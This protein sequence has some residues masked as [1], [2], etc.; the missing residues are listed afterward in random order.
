MN[1][2]RCQTPLPVDAVYCPRCGAMSSPTPAPSRGAGGPGDH[3]S[4]RGA[5][6]PG[7]HGSTLSGQ[8][9]IIHSLGV[10]GTTKLESGAVFANRYEV[11]NKLGEGGMGIVYSAKDQTSGL[12]L[13]LK[14]IHPD[15]VQ[16][17][18]AVKRLMSEGL[19]AREIRHPNIVAVYD[20]S[21]WGGQPYFTMEYVRGRNLRSWLVEN[22]N[23][24][25]EVALDVAVG[26]IKAILAG[27]AEAHRMGIVHRDLKPENILLKGEPGA[28]G[29]QLKIVDFGI[30]KAVG[31][32]RTSKTSFGAGGG[33]GTPLYMAPEQMTSSEGIKPSAD[34]YSLSVMLYEMLMD[35]LPQARFEPVSKHRSGVPAAIDALIEKGLSV[36]PRSRFQTAAEFAEA[37]DRALPGERAPVAPPPPQVAEPPATVIPPNPRTPEPSDPRTVSPPVVVLTPPVFTPTL[38]P[39]PILT[40][41]P[42]TP[43][44]GP[45]PT[46]VSPVPAADGVTAKE[47]V[48]KRM[49]GWLVTGAAIVGFALL[50]T[51]HSALPPY[52]L[53][54]LDVLVMVGF[55]LMWF[56]AR[57]DS[58]AAVGA[59]AETKA[60][61]FWVALL[62]GVV[63]P[64]GA[65]PIVM[66]AGL[67]AITRLAPA[68]QIPGTLAVGLALPLAAVA[69]INADFYV[70]YYGGT[71]DEVTTITIAGAAALG[72]WHGA[73]VIARWPRR[74]VA[75]VV[76]A[77]LLISAATVIFPPYL[78]DGNPYF[79]DDLV[80]LGTSGSFLLGVVSAIGF[81]LVMP[82]TLLL[83]SVGTASWLGLSAG[84]TV[85][86][87]AV[88]AAG[89]RYMRARSFATEPA[90]GLAVGAA[91]GVVVM[92]VFVQ[93]FGPDPGL[94]SVRDD[95]HRAG[96]RSHPTP[97]SDEV[98]RLG[99][100]AVGRRDVVQDSLAA[101]ALHDRVV[102][103]DLLSEVRPQAHVAGV[104]DVAGHLRHGNSL[105]LFQK[106]RVLREQ[107]GVDFARLTRALG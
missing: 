30:A 27:L 89:I 90:F 67:L 41:A 39:A 54:I 84:A 87:W 53:R 22:L 40:P 61:A 20:V 80:L 36:R 105:A 103:S 104:A 21:Q 51:Q 101:V 24:D 63:S 70:Y 72:A 9:T 56:L 44:V 99:R 79:R 60:G 35:A 49:R 3:G 85:A 66:V 31:A 93:Y 94:D 102:A 45:A 10:R 46:L 55:A 59:A 86:T 82:L 17:E 69:V 6:D 29:F 1:C 88:S 62:I 100:R 76:G 28:P 98:R 12:E 74:R 68:S 5:G 4:S 75:V 25:L 43:P 8:E 38:P 71:L 95:A 78:Q 16:G 83:A 37:L 52:T 107:G 73:G 14:L 2:P 64:F 7:D 42:P 48:R 77:G 96:W 91:V 92:R 65:S 26:L 11:I 50:A 33:A 57:R 81:S 15:L 19:T 58:S 97:L 106:L 47:P 13:V 32:T 23:K 18:S 34:L